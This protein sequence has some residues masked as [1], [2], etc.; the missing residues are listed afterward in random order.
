[1]NLEREKVIL[2]NLE[3]IKI[4]LQPELLNLS[5]KEFFK[6]EI[7]NE[8]KNN[9]LNFIFDFSKI[10]SI[11]SSGLGILIGIL[12][13]IKKHNGSLVISNYNDKIKTIFEITKLNL[14]FDL[15]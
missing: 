6:E 14:V 3:F 7:E 2:K 15:L 12:S 10:E 1:M 5:N 4:K 13:L 9:N 8:I 11:N